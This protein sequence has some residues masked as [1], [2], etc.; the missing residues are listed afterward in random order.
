[1]VIKWWKRC[2]HAMNATLSRRALEKNTTRVRASIAMAIQRKAF[3]VEQM[4][5]SDTSTNSSDT[6]ER[7]TFRIESSGLR[8]LQHEAEAI[9]GAIARTKQE[10]AMLHAGAS[11]RGG[12]RAARELDA[13][14]DGTER[15][16][17][18]IMDAAETIAKAAKSLTTS[19]T[20]DDAL[21]REIRDNVQRI[22]EACNFQDLSGQRIAKVMTMLQFIDESIGR[23][24]E[25]W[26]GAEAFKHYSGTAGNEPGLLH[27]PK[28]AGDSGHVTQDDIDA[29]L[30]SD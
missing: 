26:G 17:H 25:I 16:A 6:V 4:C 23:M 18:Q 28:L 9:H 10:I 12:P 5:S 8:Q 1:M 20:R 2:R 24:M 3:R 15:A 19:Q 7:Q 30:Q 21:T 29:I 11:G 27:G 13:V 14:V 22:F